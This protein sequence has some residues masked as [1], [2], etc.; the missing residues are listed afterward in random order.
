MKYTAIGLIGYT[1]LVVNL[2]K[3]QEPQ[4]GG[5]RRD[6]NCIALVASYTPPDNGHPDCDPCLGS[7]TR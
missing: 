5:C 2:V 7:G 1:L 3:A 6:N 4:R